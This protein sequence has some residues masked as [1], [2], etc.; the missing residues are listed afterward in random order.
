MKEQVV[1]IG[2]G[3]G[4]LECAYILAKAGMQVTVLEKEH[5]VGGCLQTFH[6]GGQLFDTG[7]HYVGGLGEGQSLRPLFDYFGLMDLPWK[8]MDEDCFDEIIIG[9]KHFAFA[10][11]HEHFVDTLAASFP[12][13]TARHQPCKHFLSYS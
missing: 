13:Q 6:R 1:V 12:A 7:L 2:S 5:Q 4:G 10:Q 3:L 8:R 11:G 9:D